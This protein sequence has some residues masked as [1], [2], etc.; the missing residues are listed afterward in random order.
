MKLFCLLLVQ[1]VMAPDKIRDLTASSIFTG[2]GHLKD[3]QK[4]CDLEIT[5]HGK[6][7]SCHCVVLA[8]VSKFFETSILLN[9]RKNSLARV[10][11]DHED[12]SH[13]LF[14]SLLEILYKGKDLITQESV[15]DFLKMSLYLQ[16]DFLTK[17]CV[18]FLRYNLQ[19]KDC[20]GLWQI[21]QRYRLPK[22]AEKCSRCAAEN[23]NTLPKGELL[24]LPK[25]MMLILLSLQKKLS[26]DEVCKMILRWVETD[27]YRR[28][29]FLTQFIPFISFPLL[30]RAYLTELMESKNH[31]FSGKFISNTCSLETIIY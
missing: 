20:L 25:S 26:M 14:Q 12:V 18:E 21:A 15:Q 6:T 13:T 1:I 31:P 17:C 9:V 16:I 11:L 10:Q 28:S 27:R 19:P 8:S 22:L 5:V 29:G 2:I 7:F 30:S 23:I 24:S 3:Q 4:F